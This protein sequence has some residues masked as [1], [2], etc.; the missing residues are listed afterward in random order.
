MRRGSVKLYAQLWPLTSEHLE[1]AAQID[2]FS[3][4]AWFDECVKASRRRDLDNGRWWT[5]AL[6]GAGSE[7]SNEPDEYSDSYRGDDY[8]DWNPQHE[9]DKSLTLSIGLQEQEDPLKALDEI[10]LL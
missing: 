6:F 4:R 1:N 5:G 3:D 2:W 7:D 9:R 8:E 10:V